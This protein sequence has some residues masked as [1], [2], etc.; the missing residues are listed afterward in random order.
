MGTLV[1][2]IRRQPLERGARTLL[3][4]KAHTNELAEL[5]D[6]LLSRLEVAQLDSGEAFLHIAP[7]T[8]EE[9]VSVGLE[10]IIVHR[11]VVEVPVLSVSS[12]A[13]AAAA[14]AAAAPSAD[15]GSEGGKRV[16]MVVDT[17]FRDGALKI[18]GFDME[19]H[20]VYEC[21]QKVKC[22]KRIHVLIVP[23]IPPR[24]F[25]ATSCCCC[26]WGW[27]WCCCCCW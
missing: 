21:P 3:V 27:W 23:A 20:L 19:N 15:G 12:S 11:S 8:E 10:P 2:A 25:R 26:G 5:F 18:T 13:A 17:V 22:A 1:V 6:Y 24:P 7:C 16:A 9:R 14:A 4:A